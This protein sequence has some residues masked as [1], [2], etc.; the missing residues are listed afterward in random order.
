M[1]LTRP[2]S[3][4]ALAIITGA[5]ALLSDALISPLMS[6]W[7]PSWPSWLQGMAGFILVFVAIEIILFG[8][9]A[10]ALRIGRACERK[11]R[12]DHK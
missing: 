10:C 11:V 7:V 5:C 2:S 9:G 3:L 4:L 8:L 1:A 6:H 12:G